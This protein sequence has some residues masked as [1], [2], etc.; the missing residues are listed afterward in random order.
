MCDIASEDSELRLKQN[1]A[2][3]KLA[4]QQ[5][6][7]AVLEAR[8]KTIEGSL[9]TESVRSSIVNPP[10]VA[11]GAGAGAVAAH[12]VGAESGAHCIWYGRLTY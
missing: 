1:E 10:S 7:I 4:T 9:A 12:S 8:V 11:G 3:L 2:T 6:Q 5:S